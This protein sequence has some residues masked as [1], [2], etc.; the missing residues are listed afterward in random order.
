LRKSQ[1]EHFYSSYG[2]NSFSW[3]A[4]ENLWTMGLHTNLHCSIILSLSAWYLRSCTYLVHSS[5]IRDRVC[6]LD[7]WYRL[8]CQ[9]GLV[10]SQGG[11][12]DLDE[13]EISR[14]LVTNCKLLSIF[15]YKLLYSQTPHKLLQFF[16]LIQ[17]M[18]TDSWD[19]VFCVC[20][21]FILEQ[22]AS[23]SEKTWY[24]TAPEFFIVLKGTGTGNRNIYFHNVLLTV[25]HSISV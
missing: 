18:E 24:I 19:N 22:Y 25:H 6:V 8:S 15:L 4:Y 3:C 9:D 16:S 10:N 13:T 1:P 5:G 23:D 20:L 21:F 2:L 7:D 14:N 11:R 17:R 12:E